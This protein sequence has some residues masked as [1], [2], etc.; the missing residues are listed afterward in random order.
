MSARSRWQATNMARFQ[1]HL[2]GWGRFARPM[3]EPVGI[4]GVV[5][6]APPVGVEFKPTST[7]R[8]RMRSRIWACSWGVLPYLRL[9]CSVRPRLQAPFAGSA[10]RA[11]CTVAE[12]SS[13]RLARARSSAASPM[14]HHGQEMSETS[15]FS[16]HHAVFRAV[17]W[18]ILARRAFPDLNRGQKCIGALAGKSGRQVK[19]PPQ[20]NVASTQK[21]RDLPE[22]CCPASVL[23]CSSQHANHIVSA[24]DLRGPGEALQPPNSVEKFNKTWT[25]PG[26]RGYGDPRSEPFAASDLHHP[27]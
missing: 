19:S 9:R 14:A 2:V 5:D 26:R 15:R 25:T 23:S 13:A 27:A 7:P 18:G 10:Q 4:E 24:A 16:G 20:V 12:T 11:G 22:G 17:E 6:A 21:I 8:W 1:R 3:Q